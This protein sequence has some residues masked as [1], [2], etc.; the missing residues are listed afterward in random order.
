MVISLV[1]SAAPIAA[2]V[3]ITRRRA[4][5]ACT[6][7]RSDSG[8][9]TA[10]DGG[11]RL[12]CLARNAGDPG[13]PPRLRGG[14]VAAGEENAGPPLRT[15]PACRPIALSK[16]VARP[17]RQA[18]FTAIRPRRPSFGDQRLIPFPASSTA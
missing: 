5:R 16:A 3:A 7:E 2:F 18:V 1:G 13:S 10:E 15:R 11:P 8:R 9:S 12:S 14:V 4:G 17:L 6:A